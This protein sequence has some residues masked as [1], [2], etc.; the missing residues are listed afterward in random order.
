MRE[1]VEVALIGKA[2]GLRGEQKLHIL[3]DFPE[4]FKKG[5]VF[6]L[7]NGEKIEI[8]RFNKN[9]N[10]VKFKSCNTPE[11]AKRYTNKKLYATFEDTKKNCPLKEGEFFWFEV[12]GSKVLEGERILGEVKDIERIS[13]TDYLIVATDKSLIEEGFA[14]RFYLPYIDRYVDRFDSDSKTVYA[15]DA[16]A[17]LENS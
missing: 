15:K 4:Q 8:E 10:L 9:R 16:F 12:V 2:V 6:Y 13:G 11:E 5:A 1:L 3:T 14:K 7:S 17:I